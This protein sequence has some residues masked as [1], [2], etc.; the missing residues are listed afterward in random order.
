MNRRRRLAAV[1]LLLIASCYG[2]AAPRP[3]PPAAPAPPA[4]AQAGATTVVAVAGPAAPCC[5]M[6]LW[7]F[8]GVKRAFEVVGGLLDRIRNRLGARFPGLEAKPEVLAITDPANMESDNPAVK[9]AA[10]TKAEEDAAEQKI[11][12]LR[13]L[14]E[15]GCAGC[16]PGIEEALLAGLDDCTEEVRFE[17][18]KALRGTTGSA[19]KRCKKEACCSPAVIAKLRKIAN[20]IEP[21]GC[22]VEPSARVRR[23]A[24]LA[25]AGCGDQPAAPPVT[26]PTEGPPAPAPLE[27][28]LAPKEA[29]RANGQLAV[30]VVDDS[31]ATTFASAVAV[32]PATGQV[33]A[34]VDG[35]A[36]YESQVLPKV[37]EHVQL[38]SYVLAPPQQ[39]EL[40]RTLLERELNSAIVA[41]WTAT[42]H[43]TGSHSGC[44]DPPAA[45]GQPAQ[46]RVNE[47][48]TQ[49]EMARY[50]QAH[51]ARFA[52]VPP[53]EIA[54]TI[55][56]EIIQ[57][58]RAA[59]ER[60]RVEALRR[61]GR[62]W[63]VFDQ[64]GP[65]H[66]RSH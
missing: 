43:A 6:T 62:V 10:E 1:A 45:P 30:A 48:V 22:Y 38:V 57:M 21:S 19:C 51:A 11:K 46:L 44:C 47:L 37:D 66:A 41:H 4:T 36:I 50:H 42:Q 13:F 20:D 5:K 17:A 33:L 55:R 28:A 40:R 59:A 56:E 27:A 49:P 64:Q 7:E 16:Y 15:M 18:V 23:Y 54:A 24:R 9:S 58:R 29:V 63:T 35:Q 39:A 2:C 8:L 14:G 12:A 3:A 25:M 31:K 26:A 32:A 60:Q 61:A 34:K 53:A 65:A 52:H